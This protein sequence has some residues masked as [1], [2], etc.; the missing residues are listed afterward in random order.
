MSS[1]QGWG[2]ASMA[3]QLAQRCLWICPYHKP[4]RASGIILDQM[5]PG[6][7]LCLLKAF[8]ISQGLTQCLAHRDAHVSWDTLAIC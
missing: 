6:N 5:E 2:P 7:W 8:Y 1:Q 4:K 3:I